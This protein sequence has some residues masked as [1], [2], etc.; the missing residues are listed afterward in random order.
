MLE[1][2]LKS[3]ND[4]EMRQ[5]ESLPVPK[6]DEVKIKLT[7]GGICGSDLRVFKGSINYASYP[8]RPGHELL[9][10]VIE[11]GETARYK[12]GT[13]VVVQPNSFCGEC[14]KCAKGKTN[15]CQ[16]K[17]SLGINTDGGFSEEFIISSRFVLPVPEELP[18]EKA[19]LIE[20]FAVVVH[21]FTKAEITKETSVA[22]I[23]CGNE[24]MLAAS[25]ASYL[26]AEVTAVDINPLKLELV[27]SLGN[28][29]RVIHPEDMKDQTFDVVIEAA[30][31]KRSIEQA[32]QHV[33]SGGSMVMIGIT[34]EANFPVA[35]VVRNE[36]T[37]YG[38][39]I[40]SFPTDFQK[41]VEYLQNDNFNIEPI[42]S[43]IM[44]VSE[45]QQ[46]FDKALSGDYGKIL[47]KF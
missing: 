46:A 34:Q 33:T 10:T 23:G 45:F 12:I 30:G 9:G 37:L 8:I 40:Y 47:L 22:I 20:P 39:I 13:R 7:Y 27:K 3:P 31:T 4:M 44:P 29:I 36:I 35:H 42:V 6:G 32:M 28:N 15:L 41:A 25:L 1:L 16:L 14:I 2:F 38:S 24:G 18:D 26:G 21:A 17:K 5:T 11:A 43:Q 19:I